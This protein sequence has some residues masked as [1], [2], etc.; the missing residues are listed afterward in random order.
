[1]SNLRSVRVHRQATRSAEPIRFL[2]HF[3]VERTLREGQFS[4][5]GLSLR[6]YIR[7][8]RGRRSNRG[9][10]ISWPIRA[11]IRDRIGHC[12]RRRIIG[13]HWVSHTLLVDASVS[14]NHACRSCKLSF[15]ISGAVRG[16]VGIWADVQNA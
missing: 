13:C 7:E 8:R 1:M 4:R 14:G 2:W 9:L 5:L 12:S 3:G 10:S 6:F 15:V 16:I 11:T